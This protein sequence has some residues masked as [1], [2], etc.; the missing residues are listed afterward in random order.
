MD[1]NALCGQAVLVHSAHMHSLPNHS[2]K[3]NYL[4]F[5]WN[6]FSNIMKTSSCTPPAFTVCQEMKGWMDIALKMYLGDFKCSY[7]DC[8]AEQSSTQHSLKCSLC[9]LPSNKDFKDE[10]RTQHIRVTAME[11][12]LQDM[13]NVF[14]YGGKQTKKYILLQ[15]VDKVS[16]G[17]VRGELF[18]WCKT[19]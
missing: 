19:L 14:V 8:T 18:A 12:M 17:N 6:V 16:I 15:A 11:Q 5:F 1:P 2:F 4:I 3:T 13:S 7:L 9:T 10:S